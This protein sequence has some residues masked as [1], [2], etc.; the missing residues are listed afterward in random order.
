M[1]VPRSLRK[2]TLDIIIG[3]AILSLVLAAVLGGAQIMRA[4]TDSTALKD[5]QPFV[6][7]PGSSGLKDSGI[8]FEPTGPSGPIV[9]VSSAPT[10]FK[11]DLHELIGTGSNDAVLKVAIENERS[12]L[13]A[14]LQEIPGF[15]DAVAQ[16][17]FGYDLMPDPLLNIEG[18]YISDGGGWHPPDTNGD[19]GMNDYVESVNI[20]MGVYDKDTGAERLNITFNAL[21]SPAPSPCNNGNS[22]D[23]IV[24][25]D[26]YYHVWLVTDF[27]LPATGAVYECIAISGGEDPVTSGWTYYAF[28]AEP[29]GAPWNDYPKLSVWSDGYYMT[30][31]MFEPWEGAWI[32]ALNRE[33]MLNG[34]PITYQLFKSGSAY[35]S[36]LSS[37]V[38]G[39]LPP[40]GS[41]AYLLT[42]DFPST[43]SLWKLHVDWDTPANSTFTGPTELETETAGYISSVPQQN[44]TMQL[45]TLGD[46][47]MFMLMYR[48]YG[49]HESLYVNHTV[50][51]GG[52]AGVRW[53]EVRDPNG[54]PF[55]YQ[56][57][58]YQPDDNYRWM[59]SI[60]AD[61]DGNLALGYSVSSSTMFPAVRY[62]GRLATDPLGTMPQGE[63]VLHQGT[64]S[65]TS[66]N[67]WGDYSAMSVDPVDD[68]TFWYTQ[69]YMAAQGG[70][71]TTR[72]G[73]FKFPSCGLPKGW[74]EG[75][76]TDSVSGTPLEGVPVE[77]A[78]DV[79]TTS[80]T[81]DSTGYYLLELPAG[82]YDLTAGPL[83]PSYP[84]PAL[85]PDVSVTAAVTT[86]VNFTLDPAP[87]IAGDATIIDDEV[88]GGNGNGVAEPGES[89]LLLYEALR[90]VGAAGATGISAH[91]TALTPGLV[92]DTADADYPD[93]AVGAAAQNLTPFV[94]TVPASFDCGDILDFQLDVTTDQGSYSVDFSV[95]L[96]APGGLVPAFS[97]DVESGTNGWT[98]GGA[99]NGWAI[100]TT[101]SHSPV[102]SWTD[103]ASNYP[104]NMNAWLRSPVIDL[105]DKTEVTFSFWHRYAFEEGYDF[106]YVEYSLDGSNWVLLE[107]SFT[108]N[109]T[110]WN[111][112]T[113][114]I[115]EMDNQ[116]MVYVRFRSISDGGV[117]AD[118]WYIDDVSISYR[119]YTCE[120]ILVAPGVPTLATP[121]DGADVF[122][123]PDVT[124]VWTA[125][126][127][128]PVEYYEVEVDGVVQTVSGATFVALELDFGPHTW[129][130]R[131]HNAI[132]DSAWTDLWEFNLIY[133]NLFLP[134]AV[135]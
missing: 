110:T 9:G 103:S 107:S 77:A 49:D 10:F 39:D 59:G 60:A 81:T 111:Q 61:Q 33:D 36:L 108:G 35:G 40:A 79:V 1:K 62:T 65:Q 71:W 5:T 43:L 37:N 12:P 26:P 53:Y 114:T 8:D 118:G 18:L 11:G 89:G 96:G 38:R 105:S 123:L 121:V 15:V 75:T 131:A 64:G 104:N 55:V 117:V 80:A 91:L 99:G 127:G 88:A 30:A 34:D 57:G 47:L 124:L 67:R 6:A 82:T 68:C 13:T 28:V 73:S 46:R 58:T 25:Y 133:M 85:E 86:T 32:W 54:T 101:S 22:G 102:S 84:D 83:L 109:N 106:G 14:N 125:G 93:L 66:T 97:D 31:N 48:N 74:I 113:Y 56:Q 50:M 116:P 45:D 129:R 126:A 70:N 23:P 92:V 72:I 42:F 130:V 115:P 90:N 16:T 51:S 44:T 87:Y 100:R 27:A 63:V 78:G 128:G 2:G 41:P 132:G 20:A 76:I 122:G 52:V 24:L 119:S 112:V 98:T 21:F 17:S 134:L 95:P 4:Q 94:I 3:V 19:V 7:A 69:M 120:P 135:R 29:D